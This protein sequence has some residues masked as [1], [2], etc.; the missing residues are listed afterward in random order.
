MDQ[1]VPDRA[2]SELHQQQGAYDGRGDL[3]G[4]PVMR[5]IRWKEESSLAVPNLRPHA[6]F[7]TAELATAFSRFL[8]SHSILRIICFGLTNHAPTHSVSGPN[9]ADRSI[10]P[11]DPGH[12]KGWEGDTERV[13]RRHVGRQRECRASRDAFAWRGQTRRVGRSPTMKP[14]VVLCC[15][16]SCG[17]P[18]LGSQGG[19]NCPRLPAKAPTEHR[20]PTNRPN[21]P[22]HSPQLPESRIA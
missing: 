7:L 6:P 5:P 16:T 11:N 9:P 3:P 19:A 10:Y 18:A 14:A 20:L 15:L 2:K 8:G 13:P 4:L 17:T 22:Q 1:P 12:R 21:R